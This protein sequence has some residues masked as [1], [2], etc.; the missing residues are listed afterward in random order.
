MDGQH[1]AA[2]QLKQLGYTDLAQYV[3][4]FSRWVLLKILVAWGKSKNTS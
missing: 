1:G 2:M 4:T 3:A